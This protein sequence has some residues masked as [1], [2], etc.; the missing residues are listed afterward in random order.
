MQVTKDELGVALE[1]RYDPFTTIIYPIG[2]MFA[3]VCAAMRT[4]LQ[5]FTTLLAV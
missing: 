1:I 4:G 3:G 5:S 2:S